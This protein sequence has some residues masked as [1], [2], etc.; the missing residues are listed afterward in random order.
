MKDDQLI[1]R[2][3]ELDPASP[4][5][6]AAASHGA[7]ETRRQILAHRVDELA[8]RRH[9][10]RHRLGVTVAA[11][12]VAAALL[13]PL[14]LL[15]PLGEDG[16]RLGGTPAPTSPVS[17]SPSRTDSPSPTDK[18]SPTGP[19]GAIAVTAPARNAT[20][21]SPV[22]IS[23]T[24]DV[25]EATVSIRILDEAGNVL[26]ETFTTATCGTGCRG[27]YTID[28]PFA[29]HAEQPGVIQVYE[30]SAMDGSRINTV[31]IPVTLVP[32]RVGAI[33]VLTPQPNTAVTS[34]V[35][36]SGTADVFEAVV[37][38][39]IIDE[40]NNVIAET[41][42]MATC[43]SGCRGDYSEPVRFVVDREQV[44]RIVVFEYSAKDGS[45]INVVRIPVTLAPRS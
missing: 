24:A 33:E 26:A 38:I 14:F 37:S 25:F 43:G 8:I 44:G 4:D 31:R 1:D 36:V 9:E 6:V 42:T 30:V 28:V 29:V 19:A 34:P 41:S 27:D 20:V 16:G 5:R 10:R 3:R 18:Q 35:T 12:L 22:T 45:M 2:L 39:R 21:T 23:G 7:D 13:V 40:M 32:D 15:L 17:P 11:A